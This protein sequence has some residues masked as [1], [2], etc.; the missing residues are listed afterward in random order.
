MS[1]VQPINQ[2]KD[3]RCITP[4]N[5]RPVPYFIILC[6]EKVLKI[7][8]QEK[9]K[10]YLKSA[11]H[12]DTE[13]GAGIIFNLMT[14]DFLGKN[15][16]TLATVDASE[17]PKARIQHQQYILDKKWWYRADYAFESLN[18]S[19][20]TEG[21]ANGDF[22]L[23]YNKATFQL[24]RDIGNNNSF[25]MGIGYFSDVLIPD[26]EARTIGLSPDSLILERD[27]FL[28][29]DDFSNRVFL[30]SVGFQHNSQLTRFYPKR[31]MDLNLS[32]Q[33]VF[34]NKIT[35]DF[36]TNVLE[37][38]SNYLDH[39]WISNFNY[40]Q[41]LQVSDKLSIQPVISAGIQYSSSDEYFSSGFLRFN[42]LGG[43]QRRLNP[44]II[45][46]PGLREG[47]LIAA[48][49]INTRLQFQYEL[50]KN[51][52]LIPSIQYSV[53]SQQPLR[54]FVNDLENGNISGNWTDLDGSGSAYVYSGSLQLGYNTP[55]GPINFMISKPNDIK[56]LRYYFSLGFIFF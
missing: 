9:P 5:T 13:Q 3:K 2:Q 41:S 33:Y 49:F 51:M 19:D 27:G 54:D 35:F 24:F 10:S 53:L 52:Y 44:Q 36:W 16:R 4:Y 38:I 26:I 50:L 32:V 40:F 29:L 21:V 25:S 31:G 48:Q 8:G 15:S 30:T 46:F 22:T 12:Y 55:I 20:Y 34:D 37:P 14:R 28:L 1:R 45:N 23:R 43:I 7:S 47:E 17:T 11:I 6:D 56:G 18:R 39:A 42:F